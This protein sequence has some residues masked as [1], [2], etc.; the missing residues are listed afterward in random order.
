MQDLEK[1]Q[2]LELKKKNKIYNMN[3]NNEGKKVKNR[4]K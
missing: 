2:E 4:K 3:Q 1:K